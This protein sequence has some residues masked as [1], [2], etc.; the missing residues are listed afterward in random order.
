MEWLKKHTDTVVVLTAILS[1]VLWMN[2]KFTDVEKDISSL[3]KDIAVIKAV[4]IMKNV[5]PSELCK[6]VEEKD[7]K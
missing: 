6:N 5:M 3:D 7:K 1:S 4:L 2:G